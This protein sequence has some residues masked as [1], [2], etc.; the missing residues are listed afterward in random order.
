MRKEL[1]KIGNNT[2]ETY[3]ALY[4]GVG[5]KRSYGDHYLPTLL[6][7]DVKHKDRLVTDHI[8][9]NYTKKFSELGR[10]KENDVLEFDARVTSYLKGYYFDKS[11]EYGLERP[12]KIHLI[13][14]RVTEKLPNVLEDK[15]ALIGYIMKTN[16]AFYLA[17]NR[18]YE[19]WYVNQYDKWLKKMNVNA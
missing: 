12:T 14:N 4:G 1:K 13:T 17:N 19:E 5:F 7:K 11:K 9:V 2:R 6:L 16:K 18:P 3:T 15:N 10:L 8:W